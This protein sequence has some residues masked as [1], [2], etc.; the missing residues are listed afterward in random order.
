MR[1]G[2]RDAMIA[3]VAMT[4]ALSVV[5]GFSHAASPSSPSPSK[6]ARAPQATQRP[7]PA[8]KVVAVRPAA[9]RTATRAAST[10]ATANRARYS[11][12]FLQCV[13]F[14]RD[15][16]GIHLAGNAHAW[17]YN[18]QGVFARGQRPE[19]GSVLNFRSSGGMRLGHV[20]VVSRV[21]SSREI[22]IDDANW[23]GPGQRKGQ[24]R[25]NASVIDVSD[26]NDWTVVRVANGIG[27][28]GREYPT[29]GFIYPRADGGGAAER[30]EIATAPRA[31]RQAA[32]ASTSGWTGAINLPE[33]RVLRL[34][35]AEMLRAPAVTQDRETRWT[36][37]NGRAI[38]LD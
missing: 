5:P 17:W 24:V 18:A 4:F 1:T 36:W 10:H 31:D 21:V 8:A 20:S 35:T 34:P 27:S 2:T 3:L 11:G 19:V 7:A 14:A 12:P 33:P 22:L 9:G 16:S 26:R 30:V 6:P 15:A 38:T 23:A 32:I 28:W 13:T 29:Y 37:S 25:R